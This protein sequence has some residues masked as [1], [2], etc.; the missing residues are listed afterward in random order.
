MSALDYAYGYV[1]FLLGVAVS[2]SLAVLTGHTFLELGVVET[3]IVNVV[4]GMCVYVLGLALLWSL[5]NLWS[6]STLMQP[7]R[8]FL[9]WALTLGCTQ[10]ILNSSSA[11]YL[12]NA[13]WF[14]TFFNSTLFKLIGR[15]LI[16]TIVYVL[17][18]R[19]SFI[20]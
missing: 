15:V 4:F 20:H 7:K 19:P 2:I 18:K 1:L 9:L 14:T 8:D 5:N 13:L 17:L 6:G 10:G 3:I 12:P 11:P 16:V